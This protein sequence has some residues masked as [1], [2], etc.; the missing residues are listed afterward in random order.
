MLNENIEEMILYSLKAHFN[1][2]GLATYVVKNWVNSD[3]KKNIC[4]NKIL[5]IL[6]KL[7]KKEL[8]ARVP[9]AYKT[10]ISWKIK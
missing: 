5:Y 2:S 7:E 9:N 10:M 8:V 4:T 6:K 3:F 1:N